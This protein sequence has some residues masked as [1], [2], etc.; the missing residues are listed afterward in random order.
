MRSDGWELVTV[1]TVT[2]KNSGKFAFVTTQDGVT[3]FLAASIVPSTLKP[4]FEGQHLQVKLT[5]EAKK[6]PKVLKVC[7]EIQLEPDE[8]KLTATG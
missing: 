6:G 4:L 5:L 2:K 8:Y 1:S 3:A 7:S